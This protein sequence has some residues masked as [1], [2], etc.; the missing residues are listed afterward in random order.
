M[1]FSNLVNVSLCIFFFLYISKEWLFWIVTLLLPRQWKFFSSRIDIQTAL[2]LKNRLVKPQSLKNKNTYCKSVN[3]IC[4]L[5]PI[6][7]WL[8]NK[9]SPSTWQPIPL[10]NSVYKL[11]PDIQEYFKSIKWKG[12]DLL[13]KHLQIYLWDIT[14]DVKLSWICD[15]E[16]GT[17]RSE[18]AENQ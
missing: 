1:L 11:W 16:V 14:T 18:T 6:A 17:I 7:R 10:L 2:R 5:M 3:V 13:H 9:T 15:F 4:I 12:R 8:Q